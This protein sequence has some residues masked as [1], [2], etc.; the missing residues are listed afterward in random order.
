MTHATVWLPYAQ[1]QTALSPLEVTQT[2]N[3][4]ITLA[5]GR[6]LIDAVASWWTACH[7]YNHPHIVAAIQEQAA[8]LPHIMLGGLIHP[9]ARRLADRICAQLPASLSH[10]FYSESGS[11]AIE[12]AMKMALQ[13]W[14]HLQAPERQHFVYFANGYHGDTFYAMSVC[15]PLT[16]MHKLFNNLLP[17]QYFQA[18][19]DNDALLATFDHWLSEHA[20]TVA[21]LMIEPL[22]QG[23]GGM[24]MHTPATLQS[25]CEIAQKH[26]VLIIMDEIFTGFG[27]TGTMFAFEQISIVPDILCLSKALTGG[28][29][30]LAMTIAQDEVYNAFLSDKADKAFMHGSTFMGHALGCAAANASLDLFAREPRISQ[31]AN[32]E[33]FLLDALTPLAD[34]PGVKGVRVKGAIGAVQL[35][36]V[37]STEE[38]NWFKQQFIENGIWCRPFGDIIYTTPAFTI[39]IEALDRI[40]TSIIT[41]VRQWSTKFYR[42]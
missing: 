6:Q 23:A 18:L 40:T 36:H 15:D 21:G 12:I 3:A 35:A 20:H 10:V 26:Q 22:V 7:G 27:R 34:I 32:I 8:I 28:T 1:M 37:L 24:K 9:Q 11:V 19:P 38:L 31:V 16:G 33:K 41:Y 4:T 25:L 17:T 14:S 5:D 39:P 29:M 2:E 30:P 13:Y 42:T